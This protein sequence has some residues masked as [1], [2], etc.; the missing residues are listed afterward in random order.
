MKEHGGSQSS[1]AKSLGL[2]RTLLIYKLKKFGIEPG[3]FK[4]AHATAAGKK[5]GRTGRRP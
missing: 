5:A 2:S 1:A 4:P 3:S